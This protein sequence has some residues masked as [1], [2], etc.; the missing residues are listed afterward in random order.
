M[1][2][3]FAQFPMAGPPIEKFAIRYALA[4]LE[5]Q[6]AYVSPAVSCA[7]LL[8]E[9]HPGTRQEHKQREW[10]RQ[11][12]PTTDAHITFVVC[13]VDD[14]KGEEDT[15]TSSSP[16]THSVVSKS[17]RLLSSGRATASLRSCNAAH[18]G[19]VTPN[20]GSEA[21]SNAPPVA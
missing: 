11:L 6:G 15:V 10:K 8:E 16:T 17:I 21:S 14:T 2:D 7:T 3:I 20:S 13:V 12:P 5:E 4:R 1:R 9:R 18:A 19:G